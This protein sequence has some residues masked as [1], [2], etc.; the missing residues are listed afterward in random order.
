MSSRS[1]LKR[2][3]AEFSPS[4]ELVLF[5]AGSLL[6]IVPCFW[7]SRLQISDLESH[8]YNA[9]LAQLI[10]NGSAPGLAIVSQK[11]NVLF[12]WL[13]SALFRAWGPGPAQKISAALC[14]LIFAWGAFA[15]I[16][17][18]SGRRPWH[19]M[20]IVGVLAWGWTLHMGFMNFYLSLGLCLWAMT[21][22]WTPH[23]RSLAPPLVLAAVL[24]HALPVLWAIALM[25]YAWFWGRPNLIRRQYLLG[26]VLLAMFLCVA[27]L[28][29]L[30]PT[31]WLRHQMMNILGADQA[32][33]F[34]SW[35]EFVLLGLLFSC[36]ALLFQFIRQ[37]G[38][39]KAFWSLPFQLWLL[40]VIL[41]LV[42]PTRVSIPGYQNALM[43]I[44]DRMSLAVGVCLCAL[45]SAVPAHAF[46]RYGIA[47]LAL[48]FFGFLYHDE[49]VLNDIEDR[50]Q[51]VVWTLPLNSRV[52]NGIEEPNL[53]VYPL[54]HMLDRIC[55][56][57]C[58][59]YA[60]YEPSTGQ[61]RIRVTA[62]NPILAPSYDDSVH[63]Q[64]GGYVVKDRDAPLY[65]VRL[66]PAGNIEVRE[67]PPGTTTTLTYLHPL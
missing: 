1:A 53:R 5:V 17:R 29:S 64:L 58:Y 7:Q 57:R 44:S 59:S 2:V 56:G 9:W 30:V 26:G 55:V 11:T 51:A 13:L 6:L 27:A 54:T 50:V 12:D 36:A 47:A 16:A 62:E 22:A 37:S 21:L 52:I 8:I 18:L 28:R 32:M 61:F 65:Q 46:V 66:N 25:T 4:Y 14:V 63:L 49:R 38:L 60:N 40:T 15:F 39:T 19:L 35:Y 67:L 43:Y 48:L 31:L 33:V 3:P 45:L 20:P 34:G 10:E 24:A 42:V 23:A 41:V